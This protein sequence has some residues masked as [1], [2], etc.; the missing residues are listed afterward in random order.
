MKRQNGS[1]DRF[2]SCSCCRHR[3]DMANFQPV[4]RLRV[5]ILRQQNTTRLLTVWIGIGLIYDIPMYHKGHQHNVDMPLGR[6]EISPLAITNLLS[7]FTA[8]YQTTIDLKL[9]LRFIIITSIA[10]EHIKIL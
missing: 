7:H 2:Y 1:G 9:T 4:K 3:K 6:T 8:F 5:K 10:H